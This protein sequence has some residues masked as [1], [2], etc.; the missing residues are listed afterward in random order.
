MATTEALRLCKHRDQHALCIAL[1]NFNMFCTSQWHALVR[2]NCQCVLGLLQGDEPIQRLVS[3]TQ[4][5]VAMSSQRTAQ[6]HWD[7]APHASSQLHNSF[8][9]HQHASRQ[10][11]QVSQSGPSTQMPADSPAATLSQMTHDPSGS[12]QHQQ[13]QR[14]FSQGT[15]RPR[16][17]ADQVLRKPSASSAHQ[18][19]SSTP[20]VESQKCLPS[21]AEVSQLIV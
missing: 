2:Y 15:E 16:S 1:N 20:A 9:Q 5:S 17:A 21:K 7:T 19:S 10:S 18:Q 12:L 14:Q 4:Q 3:G 8:S 11:L 13:S 6:Y